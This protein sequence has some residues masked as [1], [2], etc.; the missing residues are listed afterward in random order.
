[1]GVVEFEFDLFVAVLPLSVHT[2]SVVP[3][4]LSCWSEAWVSDDS[5][6]LTST[7][8]HSAESEKRTPR[9]QPQT[10]RGVRNPGWK[11]AVLVSQTGRLST[12]P[13]IHKYHR[14]VGSLRFTLVAR[15][16]QGT[17]GFVHARVYVV[18]CQSQIATHPKP[19]LNHYREDVPFFGCCME[20]RPV[21]TRPRFRH[22]YDTRMC[23]NSEHNKDFAAGAAVLVPLRFPSS[24]VTITIEL[25]IKLCNWPAVG[26]SQDQPRHSSLDEIHDVKVESCHCN[27]PPP[28]RLVQDTRTTLGRRNIV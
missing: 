8:T 1:M 7:Q 23:G 5:D 12:V 21:P 9:R 3:W 6:P 15:H 26:V 2:P 4:Y 20:P 27:S 11:C 24:W 19:P 10:W 18:T 13:D 17:Q 28:R 16:H 25:L 14:R 22:V